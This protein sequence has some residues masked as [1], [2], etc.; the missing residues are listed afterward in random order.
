MTDA[1]PDVIMEAGEKMAGIKEIAERCNV[2]NTTVS[3]VLNGDASL[4]VSDDVRN[5][6][7]ECAREIGYKTP[8]QRK[9]SRKTRIAFLSAE[10]DRP[11]FEAVVLAKL[12]KV[13]L[14]LNVEMEYF[15]LESRDISGM[16]ILGEF[17]PEEIS[18]YSRYTKN[19]ILI[20]NLGSDYLYDSIMMDYSN[21]EKQVLSF[22][23][24][25]GLDRIGY[26]GGYL[27]RSGTVIGRHRSAMFR[28]LLEEDGLFNEEFFKISGMD[29]ESGYRDVMESR[30]VP[31]AIF[32]GDPEYARGGMRALKERG[33]HPV[34]VCYDNFGEGRDCGCDYS[35]V[36]FTDTVWST[37]IRMLIERINLERDQCF[38][39]YC[40]AKLENNAEEGESK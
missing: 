35:M 34:T 2:S 28:K 13:A 20:N 36:I 38:C 9:Q 17:S 29:E 40:P 24:G 8:R 19:I 37:A 4:S 12:R 21:S 33:E 18:F 5:A 10:I 32:F 25:L 11:G 23:K 26:F 7:V 31:S 39:I 30:T 16:I 27:E 3:R 22:F 6:V 1:I 14:P 15:S